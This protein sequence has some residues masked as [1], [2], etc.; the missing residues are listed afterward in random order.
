M[1]KT[2]DLTWF[3]QDHGGPARSRN[4]G[5]AVARG[6]F[7]ALL[8]FDD[9]WLPEKLAMQLR[10]RCPRAASSSIRSLLTKQLG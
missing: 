2:Q 6:Q 3:Q 5:I 9:V 7:L 4:Q 8:D 10:R 1:Q